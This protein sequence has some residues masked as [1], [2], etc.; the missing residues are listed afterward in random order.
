V[1]ALDFQGTVAVD[2]R[3]D[4]AVAAVMREARLAGVLHAAAGSR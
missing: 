3:L 2:G 4:A 1:L